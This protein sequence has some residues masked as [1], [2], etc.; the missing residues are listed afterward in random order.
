MAKLAFIGLGVMGYPMAGHLVKSGHEVTVYN[1]TEQKAR[2][3][4]AEFGG[5]YEITPKLAAQG[6]DMVFI[7]VG[8]DEDLRQVTLGEDGALLGMKSGTILVDHTTASADIAREI[9]AIAAKAGIGFLDAPVSGGQAGAENG[10]L[11]MMGRGVFYM[12]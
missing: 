10:V 1:R 7:C 9:G 4:I 2:D 8:N 12:G 5:K 3:W 6:Q 11:V